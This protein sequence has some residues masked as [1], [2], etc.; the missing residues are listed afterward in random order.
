[1]ALSAA[2]LY[3]TV[4]ITCELASSRHI[5]GNLRIH[6]VLLPVPIYKMH[7]RFPECITHPIAYDSQRKFLRKRAI[8][9]VQLPTN[10]VRIFTHLGRVERVNW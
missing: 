9:F 7:E 5:D 1:M 8:D 3:A 6:V 4:L 2:C 10:S